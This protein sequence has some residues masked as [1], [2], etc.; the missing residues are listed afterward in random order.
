MLGPW[1]NLYLLNKSESIY[2]ASTVCFICLSLA[3][4]GSDKSRA[5][6]GGRQWGVGGMSVGCWGMS[7]L[8][9]PAEG[10]PQSPS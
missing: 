6:A 10:H 1:R 9:E 3:P 2:I 5:L 4:E 8:T 7:E